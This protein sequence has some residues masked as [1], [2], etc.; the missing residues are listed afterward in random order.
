[1][2]HR[3][4]IASIRFALA[5]LLYAGGLWFL[6]ARP[7]SQVV[8]LGIPHLDK[9]AHFALYMGLAWLIARAF[10]NLSRWSLRAI[11]GVSWVL[12][13]G[14]GLVDEWHQSY[15]PGRH[16]DGFDLLADALGAAA[17]LGLWVKLTSRH[18]MDPPTVSRPAA[19]DLA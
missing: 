7:A 8:G 1:V 9:L 2:A 16:A 14:Y 11:V 17:A 18:Q 6:S 5:P 3:N 10:V 15:V 4:P 12:A 13:A 19:T